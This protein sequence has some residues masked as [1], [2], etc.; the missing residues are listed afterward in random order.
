MSRQS[1]NANKKFGN[2]PNYTFRE[3]TPESL[4]KDLIKLLPI[5]T[6]D[7]VLDAGSGCNKVWFNNLPTLNKD[8][9]ELDEGKDFYEYSKKVDWVVG[10]PPY[11]EF[12]EFLFKAAEIC[13]KGFAFLINH[14]RLNQLTPR[15]LKKLEEYGFRLNLIQIVSIKEWFGRYYFIAFSKDKNQV[16]AF[17]NINYSHK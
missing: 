4:V 13:N 2:D 1:Y 8:E 9:V 3:Y 5:E 15:R 17:S 12:I 14:G 10:N 6:S 11:P 7:F 16:I